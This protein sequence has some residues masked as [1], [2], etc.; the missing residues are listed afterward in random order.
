MI[1]AALQADIPRVVEMGRRFYRESGY[2]K[3]LAENP[4][5]MRLL[6][7]QVLAGEGL[8]VAE[9]DGKLIGMFG[10]V[11]FPHFVSG[12]L[13]AAEV[14]WWME[15]EHRGNGLK[16][17]HFAEKR[18]RAAGAKRLQM[19]APN[20]QVARVYE[21]LRYEFVEIAYQKAL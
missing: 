16:L 19:I 2:A 15:P 9:C 8:L 4:E 13:I 14:V 3:H 21:R 20:K 12:E 5:Q 10:Y 18:A 6:M 7:E 17:L 1:R 11:L